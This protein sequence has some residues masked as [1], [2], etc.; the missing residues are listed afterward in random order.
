[1]GSFLRAPFGQLGQNLSP[2]QVVD[3]VRNRVRDVVSRYKGRFLHWDVVNEMLHGSY[4]EE[5]TG[6]PNFAAKI[7]ALVKE[8]DPKVLTFVNDYNVIEQPFDPS[9]TP[10]VYIRVSSHY[11]CT[12]LYLCTF[13]SLP[14]SP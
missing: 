8:I 13:I 11:C 2:S 4:F 6:D 10:E 12:Y 7:Y 3:A 14:L 1:M 5:A 9:S